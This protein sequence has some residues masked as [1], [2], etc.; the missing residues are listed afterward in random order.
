MAAFI[1]HPLEEDELSYVSPIGYTNSSSCGYCGS[2][3]KGGMGKTKRY[4]YYASATSLTPELYQDLLDRYWRRSGRLLYRPNQR[5]SCCPHYT[6][7]QDTAAFKPSRDQRQAVNR[8]NRY[9]IGKE[10][11]AAAARL[12][13]RSREE[14]KKRDAEFS[15]VERI[16]EA[17]AKNLKTPPDPAHNFTVTLEDDSFTEEKYAVYENY[18]R[19]VHKEGSGDISR[20]G[21]RRFL[22]DSPV[23]RKTVIN[24][25]GKEMQLG[26]FHHCYRLDGKLVAIGVLDLLPHC[27]SAVYF[28]YHESIHT[29]MPGKLGALQEIALAAEGGYRYWYPGFYIH[30]CPKMRYKIDYLPQYILDPESLTWDLLDKPILDLLDKKPFV[31]YSAEKRAMVES[32]GDKE[33]NG[34][35]LE[36]NDSDGAQPE[37]ESDG[38]EPTSIFESDM[39]G[40]ASLDQMQAIDLDHLSLRI[41]KSDMEYE[42]S[43]LVIWASQSLSAAGGLKTKI[44]E[45]VAAIG[46]DLM[47]SVCLDLS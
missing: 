20:G 36:D 24:D 47:H 31:S 42:T 40:V 32:N 46:P 21:F 43:D 38:E 23:R 41:D 44:A 28:L 45:F 16:H 5:Q 18:Q 37:V 19:V 26:S 15:L 4:S 14:T 39:P 9:V 10:Y 1:S 8:F 35:T 13:P 17:E 30:S 27:V 12:Y 11:A 25:Q 2:G 33:R 6:I 29:F 3:N 22:F 34:T 7:R